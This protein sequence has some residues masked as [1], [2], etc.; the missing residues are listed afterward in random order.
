MPRVRFTC[1]L[2]R[3]YIPKAVRRD[4]NFRA[5]LFL[6]Y[7]IYAD[8]CAQFK[9]EV[10]EKLN[11]TNVA[12]HLSIDLLVH[13]VEL[14]FYYYNFLSLSVMRYCDRQKNKSPKFSITSNFTFAAR[15]KI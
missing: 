5:A 15:Q 7:I 14:F 11:I 9:K 12:G 4:G 10:C 6:L 8:E 3:S 13:N 2:F 1:E